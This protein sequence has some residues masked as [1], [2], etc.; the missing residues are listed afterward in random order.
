MLG[1]IH[2]FQSL[3][4]VDGPGIRCVVFLQGCPLRCVCCHNPDTW[5][6]AGGEIADSH[7]LAA[8]IFRFRNYIGKNGGVT[9]SGGEPLLQPAFVEAL[10]REMKSGGIH[11]ALDTSGCIWN[12]QIASLLEATDLVLLDH[13]YAT[14]DAYRENTRGSMEQTEKFLGELDK[15]GIETWLR[16]VIIP[17]LT[18]DSASTQ[19]LREVARKYRCVTKVELLPFRKICMTK[20]EQMGIPFPLA[21]VPEMQE[22]GL[23]PLYEILNQQ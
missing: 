6:L 17:G 16:R 3:G 10:F 22:D 8:K 13:K 4:A 9:V 2:S 19:Q 12:E 15:R 23:E 11:T 21:D 7:A 20:Y 1:R 14:E 5:D 18:D